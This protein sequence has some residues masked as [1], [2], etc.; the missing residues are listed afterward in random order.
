[1]DGPRVLGE[2][3]AAGITTNVITF[4]S[5][6]TAAPDYPTA[7]A[8]LGEMTAAGVT[9]NDFTATTLVRF[10]ESPDQA[11]ELRLVLRTYK[12]AGNH[13]HRAVFAKLCRNLN[14]KG[15]LDWAFSGGGGVPFAAFDTPIAIYRRQKSLTTR[16]G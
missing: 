5:L 15:L 16:C 4:N 3:T 6:I 2:M 9:P 11:S 14:A 7:R 13:F 12:V 10:L 1:S 8:V